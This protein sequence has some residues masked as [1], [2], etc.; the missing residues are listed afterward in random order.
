LRYE[1]DIT[2]PAN[3]TYENPLVTKCKLAK[4]IVTHV[5]IRGRYGSADQLRCSVW[6][7][8]SQ[9]WPTNP[10]ADFKCNQYPEEWGEYYELLESPYELMVKTWN[11]DDT[12][13]HK[14]TLS[15]VILPEDI[16]FGT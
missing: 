12:F 10:D 13:A 16:V 8:G 6:H 5:R 11:D 15:I 4:G 1:F 9:L 2:T 7:F 14:L 3:T